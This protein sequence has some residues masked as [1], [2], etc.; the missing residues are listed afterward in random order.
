VAVWSPNIWEWPVALVAI[1]AA[2]GVMVPLNTRYRGAEAARILRASR[3]KALVTIDHFLEIDYLSMLD[4][5]DLPD[6]AHT[7]VLRDEH[8]VSATVWSDLPKLGEE[9]DDAVIEER[10]ARLEP[11]DLSD[12]VYTSGTTGLPKGVMSSHAQTLRASTDWASIVGLREGDRYL[13]V[14]P[15][16]HSFGYRAGIVACL[17]AGAT[18]VIQPVFDVTTAMHNVE[19]HQISVFPGPPALYQTILAHPDLYEFNLASLRLAVTGAASIPVSLV[20]QL[21]DELGFETVVT[22]YGL[23]EATGF[24]SICRDGDD[25][26]TVATTSGRAFPGVE[27]KVVDAETDTSDPVEELPRGEVGEIVLR[28]YNVMQGYYQDPDQT[29]ATVDGDGWLRTGDIGVMDDAGYVRITDR[30]KDMFIVGGFNA[31]PAEIENLLHDHGGI[32]QVAVIGVPDRRLGEVGMAFVVP[33]HGA[34]LDPAEI[35]GW[36]REQIAN[37]KAPRY[38]RVVDSLPLNAA[39]KVL[40]YELRTK[41]IEEMAT[42]GGGSRVAGRVG[43]AAPA[44]EPPE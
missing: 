34:E 39:G 43:G 42:G 17:A 32:A 14:N 22:A 16:F 26:E 41:A 40:K 29:A 12:L 5:H 33:E 3:S 21:R 4:G 44:E 19:N 2:G 24:V 6:L 15:F 35:A 37:F 11:G 20:E 9:I 1:Q 30:K 36:A 27:I 7:I 25:A 18:M 38:V 10:L 23:S 31:Y 13:I 8:E 28:G